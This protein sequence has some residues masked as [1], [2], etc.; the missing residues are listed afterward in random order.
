MQQAAE[1]LIQVERQKQLT[2]LSGS[3]QPK[4]VDFNRKLDKLQKIYEGCQIAYHI[5]GNIDDAHMEGDVCDVRKPFT[6]PGMLT[7]SF[8]PTNEKMGAYTFS[9]PFDAK[10][11]GSYLIY[12]NGTMLIMGTGCVIG[13]NCAT[14][15]HNWTAT[16]ID[17]KSCSQ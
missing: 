4:I 6:L 9:G 11:A 12:E 5:S 13:D 1:D 14:Y 16:R 7:F 17:P 2:G 3:D 10:G 8:T 15:D